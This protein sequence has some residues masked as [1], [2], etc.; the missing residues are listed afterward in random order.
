VS[1][2]YPN[3]KKSGARNR[4]ENISLAKFEPLG[5]AK[6]ERMPAVEAVAAES[7]ACQRGGHII[8]SQV[9]FEVRAGSALVLRGPNGSGKTTLLRTI[10]GYLTPAAGA[11]RVKA[12]RPHSDEGVYHYI[13]HANGIKPRLSVIENVSFW[14][15]FYSGADDIEAAEDALDAF[16]LLNLASF[17]AGH[18]SQGQARRLGLSRLLAARRPVWL[19]DEP[20]VSLDAA[21]T[22]LLEAAIA[23]HLSSGGLAI[24]STHL[25]LARPEAQILELGT[26]PRLQ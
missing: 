5:N 3:I 15:H 25:D 19:L 17:N 18:L 7:L 11:M 9:N 1:A 13:G 2:S 26:A 8:V 22:R 6:L 20:S 12:G 4:E 23:A 14:Q 10:A 21:S 16:G 24:I